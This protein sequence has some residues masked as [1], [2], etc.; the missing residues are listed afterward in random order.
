M[1]TAISTDIP[2]GF[3]RHTRTS[4]ITEPWEPIYAR[5]TA[6]AFI[7]GLRLAKPHTNSRGMV[8]G[9]LISTLADNAMGLSCGLHITEPGARL[10]TIS[11]SVDFLS[12]ASVGQWLEVTTG[13]VKAGGSICFAQSLVT[14]DGEPCARANA[15]FK[16][17]KPRPA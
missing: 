13:F 12:S 3:T 17:V 6:T 1:N 16:I 9:G 14:A 8:H 10:V 7:L 4:P 15:T 5:K 11:L 2:D